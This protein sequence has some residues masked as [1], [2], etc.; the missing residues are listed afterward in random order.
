MVPMTILRLAS[1]GSV[2]GTKEATLLC[3][4]GPCPGSSQ[5]VSPIRSELC[6]IMA[7]LFLLDT[8]REEF[9]IRSGSV[10]IY[11]GCSKADELINNPGM[12]FKRNLENNNDLHNE[13]RMLL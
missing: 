13:S 1:Y 6:S 12:K 9:S 10:K 2:L 8:L 11:K 7:T 3:M 4:S 5:T